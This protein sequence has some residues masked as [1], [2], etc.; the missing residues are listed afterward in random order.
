MASKI[1][2]GI[3]VHCLNHSRKR[4]NFYKSLGLHQGTINIKLPEETDESLILP[5]RRVQ[6]VDLIDVE[7]DFLIRDCRL[8]G[9]EGYQILPI[10]KKTGEP[11]G[12]HEH[13]IIEIALREEIE[14][15][16]NEELEVELQ[17]F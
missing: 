9:F 6:G 14:I 2:K 11:R 8:K 1:V 13:K 5:N 7:Q 17:G 3:Y 4:P 10:D 15:K 12:Y 16:S